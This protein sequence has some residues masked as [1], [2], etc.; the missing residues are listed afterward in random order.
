MS[1]D[2]EYTAGRP[3]YMGIRVTWSSLWTQPLL[4]ARFTTW[5]SLVFHLLHILP[6]FLQPSLLRTRFTPVSGL[7]ELT[8][9]NECIRST[10]PHVQR[11]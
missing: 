7:D 11:T 1:G 2:L 4:G 8:K 5:W 6:G 10:A 3:A 9:S